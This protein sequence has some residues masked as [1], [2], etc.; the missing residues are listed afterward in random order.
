MPNIKFIQHV[1]HLELKRR[2][3]FA[4]CES[5]KFESEKTNY[6]YEA[7]EKLYEHYGTE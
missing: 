1:G 7:R 5:C 6:H 3:H 4:V 2:K